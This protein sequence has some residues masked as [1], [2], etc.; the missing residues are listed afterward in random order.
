MMNA[1]SLHKT[2]LGVFYIFMY[3]LFVTT[4][5]D[6]L[7]PLYDRA[8]GRHGANRNMPRTRL[9]KTFGYV[10]TYATLTLS[11]WMLTEGMAPTDQWL[12]APTDNWMQGLWISV[13]KGTKYLKEEFR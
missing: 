3:Y 6:I 7:S 9:E 8:V 13:L 2:D 4:L 5:E 11:W 10:W 12:M 1:M